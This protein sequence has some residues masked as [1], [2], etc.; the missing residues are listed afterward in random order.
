ND[1]DG[2]LR[3][4][5]ADKKIP[6][7]GRDGVPI[8]DAFVRRIFSKFNPD[9]VLSDEFRSILVSLADNLINHRWNRVATFFEPSYFYQ[10]LTFLSGDRDLEVVFKQY[11]QE[12]F[13]QISGQDYGFNISNR[14]GPLRLDRITGI[15][16]LDVVNGAPEGFAGGRVV[17]FEIELEDASRVVVGFEFLPTEPYIV[18]GVG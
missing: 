3:A 14:D 9:T 6:Y 8:E 12:A 2:T 18:G 7:V 10:Q 17:S 1:K 16:Y 15:I 4:L 11:I 13:V 5:A